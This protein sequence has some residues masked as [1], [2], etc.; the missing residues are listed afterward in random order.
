M[1]DELHGVRSELKQDT[2]DV[3]DELKQDIGDLAAKLD[4]RFDRLNTYTDRR[5]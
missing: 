4:T 1:R 5:C 2:Q 3:R